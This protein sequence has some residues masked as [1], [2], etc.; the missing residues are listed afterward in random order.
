MSPVE[1]FRAALENSVVW[2][3]AYDLGSYRSG[4]QLKK[5]R[6]RFIVE[7]WSRSNR[8]GQF[9]KAAEFALSLRS[10]ILSF[11]A[12]AENAQAALHCSAVIPVESFRAALES[13]IVWGL[14]YD[15]ESYRSGQQL[16]TRRQRLIVLR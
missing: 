4:Q 15:L 13:S 16:K 12:A 5:R 3:L 8:S 10:R 14:A 1:S 11:R 6:R 9:L 7:Q 2:G